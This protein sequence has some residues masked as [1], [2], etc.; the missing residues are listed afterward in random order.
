MGRKTFDRPQNFQIGDRSCEASHRSP[1]TNSIESYTDEDQNSL[2]KLVGNDSERRLRLSLN[3]TKKCDRE[4]RDKAKILEQSESCEAVVFNERDIGT[5]V[6]VRERLPVT[7]MD[8]RSHRFQVL[9]A[10]EAVDQYSARKGERQERDEGM[11]SNQHVAKMHLPTESPNSEQEIREEASRKTNANRT[12]QEELLEQIARDKERKREEKEMERLQ[13]VIY[14]NNANNSNS[15]QQRHKQQRDSDGASSSPSKVN[16]TAAYGR[17]DL[18]ERET[19]REKY[20][21]EIKTQIEETKKRKEEEKQKMK[22]L[23]LEDERR[24]LRD[25]EK[26]N[27]DFVGVTAAGGVSKTKKESND[28]IVAN[29]AAAASV[30]AAAEEMIVVVDDSDDDEPGELL[31]ITEFVFAE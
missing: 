14:V 17:R 1:F 13:D 11:A 26:M 10:E 4:E 29:K 27:A 12:Y 25:L 28:K 8:Q 15:V 2:A 6:A 18:M 23:E 9:E 19:A 30:A 7:N 31:S 3:E 24:I 5:V 16:V 21:R 22:E 20:E